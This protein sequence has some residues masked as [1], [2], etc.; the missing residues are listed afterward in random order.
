MLRNHLETG[1]EEG[2]KALGERITILHG[3]T[4]LFVP[5]VEGSVEMKRG[6]LIVS[7]SNTKNPAL[8]V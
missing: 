2:I 7:Y 3:E 1:T 5:T 4:A 8:M 6:I